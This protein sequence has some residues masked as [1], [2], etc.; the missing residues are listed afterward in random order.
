MTRLTLL[1]LAI[2]LTACAAPAASGVRPISPQEAG[3]VVIDAT[4]TAQAQATV[5]AQSTA[6]RVST[7]EAV[8]DA[9]RA[10]E[11]ELEHRQAA[12]IATSEQFKRDLADTQT[13]ADATSQTGAVTATTAAQATANAI[14][15]EAERVAIRNSAE[16]GATVRTIVVAGVVTLVVVVLLIAG[17]AFIGGRMYFDFERSRREDL[18]EIDV[19]RLKL[20]A[21]SKA[22]RESRAGTVVM[23]L[24]GPPLVLPPAHATN[25]SAALDAAMSDLPVVDAVVVNVGNETYSLAHLSEE[26][27]AGYTKMVELLE[28]AIA[29]HA[30]NATKDERKLRQVPDWRGLRWPSNKWQEARNLFGETL[31]SQPGVG[32]FPADERQSLADLLNGVRYG[33]VRVV[34]PPPVEAEAQAL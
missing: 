13:A 17:L 22:M 26:E 32:T 6:A 4:N 5:N 31:T 18:H 8:N 29:W 20:E 12:A 33:K 7:L 14:R 30:A 19:M 27:K 2:L 15:D 11:S 23:Q 16:N 10:T 3:Q 25:G 9:A 28:A 24:S 1:A 21:L 34:L